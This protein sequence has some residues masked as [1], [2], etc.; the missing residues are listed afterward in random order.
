MRTTA[1]MMF[2]AGVD[3]ASEERLN[4]VV[5]RLQ[6]EQGLTVLLISHELSIVSRY[7]T[8]VLC[9]GRGSSWFGPPEQVLTPGRLA[10]IYGAPVA[11]HAHGHNGPHGHDENDGPH[12]HGH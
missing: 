11:F 8:D 5:R 4:E 2:G 6:E 7:A 3:M 9:L 12:D 10:E 1:T